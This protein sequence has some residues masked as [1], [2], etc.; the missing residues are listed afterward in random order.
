MLR[1]GLLLSICTL[2]CIVAAGTNEASAEDKTIK[3]G[4]LFPMSGPGSYFRAEDRQGIELAPEQL[5]KSGGNGHQ[6]AIQDEDSAGSSLPAAPVAKR[7]RDQYK[8]DG[9]IGEEC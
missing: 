1:R 5:N 4:G 6:F 3:I 7:L 2:A 8:P 9:I